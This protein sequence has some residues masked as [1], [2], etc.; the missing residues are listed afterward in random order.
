MIII[1]FFI[2]KVKAIKKSPR[3]SDFTFYSYL[4]VVFSAFAWYNVKNHKIYF[5]RKGEIFM[6]IYNHRQ[7]NLSVQLINLPADCIG[8]N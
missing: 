8:I 2:Y 4:F 6:R 1:P 5:K 3:F 7:H